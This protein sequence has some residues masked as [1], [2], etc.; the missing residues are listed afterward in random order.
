MSKKK[1]D[2]FVDCLPSKKHKK[3]KI[4]EVVALQLAKTI[5]Y[6]VIGV[7][8]THRLYGDMIFTD[9]LFDFRQYPIY[10]F[11]LYTNNK[12]IRQIHVR[13]HGILLEFEDYN[14]K[15]VASLE[16]IKYRM[17]SL[18]NKDAIDFCQ[19]LDNYK[20]FFLK[21][22]TPYKD[23]EKEL[24][25]TLEWADHIFEKHKQDLVF[26]RGSKF[27]SSNDFRTNYLGYNSN[28]L[29]WITNEPNYF[30]QDFISDCLKIFPL[31]SH[32]DFFDVMRVVMDQTNIIQNKY[33]NTILGEIVKKLTVKMV[34]MPNQRE[35]VHYFVHP[36]EDF[37]PIFLEDL[38]KFKCK[39]VKNNQQIQKKEFDKKNTALYCDLMKTY[40]L[41]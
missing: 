26:L 15:H 27:I 19:I 25:S 37:D 29:E 21:K 22:N 41:K 28:L 14:D 16:F 39:N 2:C 10:T 11:Q 9:Q 36:K 32:N 3:K 5:I 23:N 24:N 12:M 18:G 4:K 13:K 20:D 1:S 7:Y 40:Y 31:K 30:S 35:F 33:I 8:Q 38:Q 17:I 6:R 34:V